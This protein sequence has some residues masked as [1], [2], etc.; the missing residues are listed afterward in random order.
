MTMKVDLINL[1]HDL[2][3]RGE[4]I[5]KSNSN[6]ALEI[7]KSNIPFRPGVYLVF[8]LN[9]EGAEDNLLY[10]GKAGVTN[11]RNSPKL[12]YHQLP[13]RLVAATKCPKDHENYKEG[14]RKDITRA[15]LWPWYIK[16]RYQ[17]G[18]KIIWFITEWPLR[19]PNDYELKIKSFLKMKYPE[20]KKSI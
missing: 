16:N 9:K 3:S 1:L 10:Y 8:S 19:N 14:G 20:W 4:I 17:N 11:N 2:T 5:L 18:I 15:K 6:Y 13:A 12:N 7:Y